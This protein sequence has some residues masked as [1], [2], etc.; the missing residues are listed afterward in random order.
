MQKGY[1]VAEIDVTDPETYRQYMPLA[2]AAI[3][4]HGGRYVVR[5]GDPQALEGERAPQRFVV[6]EFDSREKAE[7]FYRSA[8]YQEAAA[9]RLR[10]SNSRVFLL[11]GAASPT[12]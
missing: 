5:G 4:A 9:V 2:Q 11:T 8:Q 6:L 3:A 7:A 1:V 12:G 10:S